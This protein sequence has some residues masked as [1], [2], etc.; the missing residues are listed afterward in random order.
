LNYALLSQHAA[1]A[2]RLIDAGA[3]LSL[4][5]PVGKVPPIVLAAY[6]EDGDTS[7]TELLIERGAEP[8][9]ASQHGETALTWA[10]RRGFPE[11]VALLE[12]AQ[13]TAVTD[14]SIDIPHRPV[15]TSAAERQAIL[16]GAVE[17]SIALLQRSSDVF[18]EN[19]RCVSCHHQ[20][21][22]GVALGW[23]RDR[24]FAVDEAAVNRIVER[25]IVTWAAR[26]EAAYEMDRPMPVPPQ[27]LGY[28][29]WGLAALGHSADSVTDA[30]VWY[31]AAIQ[32]PDGHWPQA[33][34]GI[35]RPPLGG[36]DIMSTALALRALQ[37]YPL[38]GR[39][40]E[41]NRR[42]E[43]ARSWLAAA[44]AVTHQD[45]VFK[46]VG[47][48]WAGTP[49]A[50]L[51]TEIA[52]LQSQQRPD[53]GWAQLPHLESD[54]WAT[55]ES[56]VALHLAGG[57]PTS[58]PAYQRGVDFLLRTQFDDGA[59]YVRA[60]AWPFQPPFDSGFPFGR[61]QWI[62][63]GAT[64]WATMALLVEA[65]EVAPAVVPSKSDPR[66][67]TLAAVT[68]DTAVN[69]PDATLPAAAKKRTE[70]LEFVR[71][72]KPVLE[73]SCA[74]CHSGD[75]PQG[76]YVVL[77]REALLRG[78]ESGETAVLPGRSGRSPLFARV[79]GT[80]PDLAMPPDDKRDKYPALTPEEL[81]A[82]RAWID[83]GALWPEGVSV[84]APTY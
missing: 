21:L 79:S 69:A 73:R 67:A 3:D 43:Q 38:A 48:A 75:T 56:L 59:W 17:R 74:G 40:E 16:R 65:G 20:N 22:P 50:E 33:G 68:R 18:L 19:R 10:R 39:R 28:G 13:T 44:R 36:S 27:L 34:G 52:Q 46:L 31:L 71:D 5:S 29:M 49:A 51:H 47:L 53:G 7:V 1:I 77:D 11:L 23:A 78:G 14:P 15:P 72:I 24:G 26:V 70:P 4:C 41:S 83:E 2:R 81:Q 32:K 61:D 54:A 64:A 55:G 63:V 25:N 58:D 12:E 80:D 37:L 82:F 66:D 45:L 35:T 60:R 76:G 84:K 57:T 9:A 6:F 62:S 30:Y 8:S 42:V